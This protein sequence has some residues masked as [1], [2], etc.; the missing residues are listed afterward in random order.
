MEGEE[1]SQQ[2]QGRGVEGEKGRDFWTHT[3]IEIFVGV[4]S[5]L[6]LC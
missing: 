4:S 6:T 5:S 2:D 1:G 3:A